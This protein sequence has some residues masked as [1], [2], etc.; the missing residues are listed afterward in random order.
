M[1]KKIFIVLIGLTVVAIFGM[2]TLSY[3]LM[4]AGQPAISSPPS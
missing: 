4:T 1:K 2:A 3:N